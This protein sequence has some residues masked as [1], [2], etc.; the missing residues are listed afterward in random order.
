MMTV[1]RTRASCRRGKIEKCSWFFSR[2]QLG[3]IGQE[4]RHLCHDQIDI[5]RQL[6]PSFANIIGDRIEEKKCSYFL[7]P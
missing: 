5:A 4:L 6:L 2:S 7:G 1:A 3:K